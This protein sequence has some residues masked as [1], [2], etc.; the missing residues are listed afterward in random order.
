MDTPIKS[1]KYTFSGH[2]EEV[3]TLEEH[4]IAWKQVLYKITTAPTRGGCDPEPI[5]ISYDNP[6]ARL[7]LYQA[8]R[9]IVQLYVKMHQILI[10]IKASNEPSSS[11]MVDDQ[12]RSLINACSRRIRRL[13]EEH[14]AYVKDQYSEETI[15][16]EERKVA[17]MEAIGWIDHL[18]GLYRGI[19]HDLLDC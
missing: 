11:V 15:M 7:A 3:K 19:H 4:E 1:Q 6:A 5:V 14:E 18:I 9:D 16:K 8:R 12:R 17:N 2:L 10:G 13:E